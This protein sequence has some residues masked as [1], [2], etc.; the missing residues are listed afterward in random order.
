[1]PGSTSEVL[2]RYILFFILI[3]AFLRFL[4]R[5]V[6]LGW[7]GPDAGGGSVSG[8]GERGP[9]ADGDVSD[10][11]YEILPEEPEIPDS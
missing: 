2:I 11:E 3:G 1:M 5:M 8:R 10:A 7:G 6:K 4:D 9:M